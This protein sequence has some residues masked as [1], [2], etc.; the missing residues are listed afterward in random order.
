VPTYSP[1]RL[2]TYEQCP[3]QYRYKYV[4]R[5]PRE[6]ETVESFMGHCVHA[7]LERLYADLQMAKEVTLPEIL[8]H[9]R[10]AWGAGWHEGIRIVRQEYTAEQ[11]R[12]LGE[13]CLTAYY[14]RHA[15]FDEGTTL[16]LE[17]KMAVALD[18]AGAYTIQ[19]I[20]DR[21][22][23]V[24]EG[25]YE[26]HDYKTGGR[27]PSQDRLDG[28]RQLALYQLAVEAAWPDAKDVE[29]VWHY[30]VFDRVLRSRRNRE[31]L[32]GL[33]R[34]TIALVEK[35]EA[36]TTFAPR[37]SPLCNWCAYQDLCPVRRHLVRREGQV[38]PDLSA[39]AAGQLVNRYAEV[40]LRRR[41]LAAELDA[42]LEAL[43]GALRT[44]AREQEAEVLFGDTHRV[45]VAPT[46]GRITL[47]PREDR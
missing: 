27:L 29:L 25:R 47:L 15:P 16:G 5:I 6:D 39:Y 3:R 23:E 44:A 34:E 4:D 35:I 21:L 8:E 20:I 22:V 28:D 9:Y 42:E 17:A 45:R 24:G 13:R 46:D 40:S 10:Q 26:I 14:H 37:E 12:R 31:E 7:A 36:D 41:A 32:E 30:L 18:E 19:G 33:K 2:S 1:S 38:Q 11:Y 43:E